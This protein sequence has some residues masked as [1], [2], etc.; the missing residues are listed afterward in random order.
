MRTNKL[1]LAALAAALPLT[2]SAAPNVTLYGGVDI[3]VLGQKAKGSSATV[4]MKSGF[5]YASR[6]GLRGVEDLGNGYSVGFILEQGFQADSGSLEL[7]GLGDRA[8]GREASLSVSGPFGKLAFGRLGTLG[9]FQSTGIIKGAVFGVSPGNASSFNKGRGL[10]FARVDNA[11]S[12]TTPSFNGLTFH[13]MYS[14]KMDGDD[15]EKWAKNNHYYGLGVKY[16]SGAIDGSAIFEVNDN[17]GIRDAKGVKE[18]AI[19]HFTVGGSYDLKSFKPF[20]IYQYS[21]Q[22]DKQDHHAF[23]LGTTVPAWGGTFKAQ[24]RVIFGRTDGS[25]RKPGEDHDQFEWTLG[26]GYDYPLSKRTYLW[27]FAGYSAATNQWKEKTFRTNI[28]YNGW[29]LGAGLAHRF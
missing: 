9:F 21:H 15:T 8:F 14:N 5:S 25:A 4:D 19:Y 10:T 16:A 24:G 2:V 6:W 28:L 27:S 17:K 7:K 18:K 26:A 12:Y 29:Q 22:E 11:I 20:A 13:A 1:F 3:G 23:A